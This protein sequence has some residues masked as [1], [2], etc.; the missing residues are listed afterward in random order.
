MV[1][2]KFDADKR[3]SAFEI[4]FFFACVGFPVCLAVLFHTGEINEM[5]DVFINPATINY[6]L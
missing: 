1:I 2:S 6:G 5:Y 3:I 4:N